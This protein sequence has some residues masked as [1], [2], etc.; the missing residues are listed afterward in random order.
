MISLSLERACLEDIPFI[1]KLEKEAFGQ[2]WEDETFQRE[3]VR[4]N[5][6][7]VIAKHRGVALASALLVWA[8]DEVQLNSIVVEPAYRGRGYSVEFLG[9]LMAWCQ[10]E[11]FSWM[12][13]EVRWENPPAWKLYHKLG[14]VTTAC[15]QNYYSD[16][17]D[18]R[19][20]W[21]GH[22]QSQGHLRRLRPFANPD[23][24]LRRTS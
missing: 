15:R 10:R 16:G 1:Q 20:M 5:G 3:L 21:A 22:L 24:K 11:E 17:E 4:S 23:L 13:L 6:A 9:Q 18:A 14:F 2:S 7:T 19:L 12:T 8:A